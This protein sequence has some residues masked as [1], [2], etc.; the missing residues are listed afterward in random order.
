MT[1]IINDMLHGHKFI[2]GYL[3]N[4][5]VERIVRAIRDYS[6]EVEVK[7]LPPNARTRED[8]SQ[9]P[10]YAII[11]NPVGQPPY[12]MFYVKNDEDFNDKVLFRII[13]SDQRS[14]SPK[15]NEFTA[16][17]ETQKRIQTQEH[18][19]RQAEAADLAYHMLKTKKHD[20]R[21]NSGLR[22]T[23]GTRGNTANEHR[24]LILGP[25]GNRGQL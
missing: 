14:G 22:V 13:S 9:A 5:D 20:Y 7:W 23:E 2:D 18:I 21:V 4:S 8:G 10:A 16:W 19:D 25:K 1:D 17:E 12:V 11:H 6:D 3:V 15:W 24:K